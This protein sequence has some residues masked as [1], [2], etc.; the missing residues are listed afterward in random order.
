MFTQFAI[1]QELKDPKQL[2]VETF[3]ED[4]ISVVRTGSTVAM[5]LVLA[6]S[7]ARAYKAIMF[8][9]QSHEVEDERAP[10]QASDPLVSN[11]K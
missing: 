10:S 2:I 5:T 4:Q 8:S 1:G 9:R 11:Q 3:R 7:M 6:S